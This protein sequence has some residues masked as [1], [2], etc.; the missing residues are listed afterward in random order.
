M[1]TTLSPSQQA[2]FT[3]YDSTQN[4]PFVDFG[5]RYLV[6]GAQ[7]LPSVLRAGNTALG[8]PYDWSQ[9][10]SQLNNASSPIAQNIDGTAN[11]LI[12]TICKIDGAQPQS[13]CSSSFAQLAFERN[14]LASLNSQLLS[15][16]VPRPTS[17]LSTMSRL[18]Q[19]SLSARP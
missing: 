10:A 8:A 3:Q 15:A 16:D 14:P 1:K 18:S 5:N 19:S 17:P 12:S 13:I 4:I 11:R 2:I 9:V 6:L 7:F